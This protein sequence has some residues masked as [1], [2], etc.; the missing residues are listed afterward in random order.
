MYCFFVVAGMENCGPNL[1]FSI[2]SAGVI[3][4]NEYTKGCFTNPHG[5][6][7]SRDTNTEGHNVV[8]ALREKLFS[9][10]Y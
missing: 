3:F 6:S 4:Y 5:R 2:L 10:L 1:Y 9:P 8:Y 7:V